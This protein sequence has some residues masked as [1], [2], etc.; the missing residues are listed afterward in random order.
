MHQLTDVCKSIP[1]LL[2]AAP[3]VTIC[4]QEKLATAKISAPCS[5]S[6]EV[7]HVEHV[8]PIVLMKQ[9]NKAAAMIYSVQKSN[10]VTAV[11][12]KD[13]LEEDEPLSEL[14]MQLKRVCDETCKPVDKGQRWSLFQTQCMVKGKACK[15]MIDSGSY[16]NGISKSVVEVLGL[17]TWRIPETRH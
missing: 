7:P 15:L 1:P 2:K 5:T 6:I 13:V 16:C 11:V 9:D 8:Q 14:N 17:S 12:S 10:V 3:A 4:S